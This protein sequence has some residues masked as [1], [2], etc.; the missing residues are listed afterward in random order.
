MATTWVLV[1]Q[2]QVFCDVCGRLISGSARA[3]IGGKDVCITTRASGLS[4]EKKLEIM[5][6]IHSA[7]AGFCGIGRL[8][9]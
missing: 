3:R 4:C 5:Q 9:K 2:E 7:D 1:E 8:I 6:M